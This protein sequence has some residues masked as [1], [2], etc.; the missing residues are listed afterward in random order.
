LPSA[1]AVG[2][3]AAGDLI[4]KRKKA[5]DCVQMKWRIQKPIRKQYEGL[6]PETTRRVTRQ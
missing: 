1:Q 5:F 3:S 6:S 4:M 2:F